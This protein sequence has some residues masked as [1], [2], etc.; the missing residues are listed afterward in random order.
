MH[1]ITYNQVLLNEL[2]EAVQAWGYE[3]VLEHLALIAK[4]QGCRQCSKI[5]KDAA[6]QVAE[7]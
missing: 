7:V 2:Y 5:I 1:K 4:E 3:S 6:E